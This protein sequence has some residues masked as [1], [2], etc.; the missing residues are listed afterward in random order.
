VTSL[1][2]WWTWYQLGRAYW[3]S[4]HVWTLMAYLDQAT[5]QTTPARSIG[6]EMA[7]WL[8]QQEEDEA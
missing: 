1:K 5:A 2:F 3:K 7:A 6:D 4:R 8:A